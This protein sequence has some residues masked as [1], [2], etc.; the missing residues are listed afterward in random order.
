MVAGKP[1][2]VVPERYVK[3]LAGDD[4]IESQRKAPKRIKKLLRGLSEKELARRPAEGKWSIKEVIAHLADGE[5]IL[6]SRLRF[7][8]A[9]DRPPI[10]GYDQDAFVERLG[11]ERVKTSQLFDAFAAVRSANVGLMQRLADEAWQRIGMHSE[12]GEESIETMI[13]MYAGHD[14]IHEDQIEAI[15]TAIRSKK[16]APKDGANPAKAEKKQ[17]TKQAKQLK[18]AKKRAAKSDLATAAP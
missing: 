7:V 18:K 9:M 12:R 10:L 6:G 15:R 1:G 17:K 8:A 3:A 2:P 13:V 14:R 11:I 4:P 16:S 5:V